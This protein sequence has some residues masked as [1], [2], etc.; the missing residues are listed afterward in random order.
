MMSYFTSVPNFA[1]Q[2]RFSVQE[3]VVK[4]KFRACV[5]MNYLSKKQ[6]RWTA[7]ATLCASSLTPP[8]QNETKRSPF[9]PFST[10][11]RTNFFEFWQNMAF[12]KKTN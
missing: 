5:K 12:L 6:Q 7:W 1:G 10:T 4:W 8:Y 9:N 3:D 11:M 2:L